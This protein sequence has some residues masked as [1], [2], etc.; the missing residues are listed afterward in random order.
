MPR[1]WQPHHQDR[2]G[3]LTP[4]L[5]QNLIV[6]RRSMRMKSQTDYL[7]MNQ[8]SRIRTQI[9]QY[10]VRILYKKGRLA[11]LNKIMGEH[12]LAVLGVSEVRWNGSGRTETTNGNVF[13]YSRMPNA[14]D[15]HIRGVGILINKN[16]RRALLERNPVS[17]R[18]ITARIQTKLRKIQY[19]RGSLQLGSKPS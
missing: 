3:K 5:F 8:R 10:N 2:A 19:Q 1:R 15:D 11:Q 14:D 18:L 4:C 12:K 16:I 13:V 17:E 9:G 6:F 7:L